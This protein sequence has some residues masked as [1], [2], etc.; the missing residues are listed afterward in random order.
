MSQS[1]LEPQHHTETVDGVQWHWAEMGEGDPVVLLHGI[2]E[3]WQCWKHQI[4]TLA[5]QFRVLAFDLKGYGRSDKSEGDYTSRTVASELLAC[6]DA[7]GVDEY[8]LAGHDWGVM[9]ADNLVHLAPQRVNR[10]MRCCLSLHRYDARNSLHH[11]WNAE[12]PEAATRLMQK[13]DAYVRV[14]M[15]SSCRPDL[16]PSEEELDEIVAEFSRPGVAQAVPRYFRDI[17]RN[18]PVDYSRFT[19]PVVYVHGEHDPRQPI[20]YCRGMADHLPGLE[21]ILVM[22]CG[23]FVTRER[24]REMTQALMWF[25]NSMLAPGLALFDRSRHH[26]LPTM[27]VHARGSWGVN[28]FDLGC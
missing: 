16:V 25:Y 28:T 12:N 15:E 5:T 7:A 17:R 2:P 1:A 3:S 26:G 13:A 27:P 14:W 11:Q 8:R 22:D 24:P 9:I 4:P 21:A 23:H 20:D 19:M 18:S 6:L 10:Y